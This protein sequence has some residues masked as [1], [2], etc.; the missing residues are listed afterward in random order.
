MIVVKM[1][2]KYISIDFFK[3]IYSNIRG[4]LSGTTTKKIRTDHEILTRENE[5]LVRKLDQVM[6]E[7]QGQTGGKHVVV[8]EE[9]EPAQEVKDF[10]INFIFYYYY[11]LVKSTKYSSCYKKLFS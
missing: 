7:Q 6:R 8:A 2:S 5:K 4:R 11:V 3:I 1:L 9:D 10:S